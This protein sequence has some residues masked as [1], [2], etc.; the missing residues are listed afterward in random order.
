MLSVPAPKP[1]A[2]EASTGIARRSAHGIKWVGLAEIITRLLQYGGTLILA[3]LLGA[4]AIGIYALFLMFSQLAYVLFDFGFSSALIQR[5]NI[6]PLHYSTTFVIYLVSALVYILLMWLGAGPLAVYVEHP[7]LTEA[8]R[9]LSVIF[10]FY[11]LNALPRIRLQRE[12]RFKRFSFI[13]IC[14]TLVNMGVTLAFAFNG[15]DYRSFVFGI[16]A[17]QAVLTLLF[18]VLAFTPVSLRVEGQAF[19]ELWTYGV[20]VLG[21]R[22]V[23]Y[24]NANI[25]GFLVGKLIGLDALGF[26]NIAYQLVDFPVQRIS[27]NVLRVM[28]PAFSK[29][30]D[31]LA[32][33][34]TLYYQVV[35]YLG[36]LLTPIFAGLALT[37]PWLIPLFYGADWQPAVIP[38]QFLA[39]VG[40]SRS[41]WTT[42]SVIFLSRGKPEKE[43]HLNMALAAALIP[44]VTWSAQWGL[45]AVALTVAL[46]LFMFVLIGQVTAFR[47]VDISWWS[48]SRRLAPALGGVGLFTFVN[49]VGLYLWGGNGSALA[50]LA[51]MIPVSITLYM[52]FL[53]MLDPDVIGRLKS[54][55]KG[56][57]NG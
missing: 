10:L 34:K 16:I 37:A 28:F 50:V 20:R 3:R 8:F 48:V 17:E 4:K 38:L 44:F 35:Y 15:Y 30:Q 42:I 57:R 19:K 9:Q 21:T 24:L 25:P 47:L 40:F 11:A 43:L 52:I 46:L 56:E 41:V 36:L 14:G 13:Q 5:K 51:V 12:M 2:P 53:K 6:R 18:N 22:V 45:N 49:L 27:K 39:L 7:Q 31:D 26:Y 33:Y 55:M 54:M 29:L 23:A 1:S 32:A